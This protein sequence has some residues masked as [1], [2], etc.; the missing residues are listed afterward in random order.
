MADKINV[1]KIILRN[2]V[3]LLRNNDVI[4]Q[5]GFMEIAGLISTL[6]NDYAILK[7]LRNGPVIMT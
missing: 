1:D 3:H 7:R 2:I 6:R 4:V 5:K